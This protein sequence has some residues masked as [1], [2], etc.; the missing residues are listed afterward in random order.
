MH[1]KIPLRIKLFIGMHVTDAIY[2][3][4]ILQVSFVWK[5]MQG[6]PIKVP[7]SFSNHRIWLIAILRIRK[8]YSV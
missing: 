2:L 3:R 8:Y 5:Q 1:P 7:A 4:E 6:P